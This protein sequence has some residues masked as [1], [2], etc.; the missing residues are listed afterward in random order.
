MQNGAHGSA[1]DYE[2]HDLGRVA[3]AGDGEEEPEKGAF[4]EE[5]KVL[6]L[7]YAEDG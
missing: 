3:E 5:G 6:M 7:D 1:L 2:E 4:G